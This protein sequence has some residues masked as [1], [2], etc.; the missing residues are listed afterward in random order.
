MENILVISPKQLTCIRLKFEILLSSY[1]KMLMVSKAHVLS[2]NSPDLRD[3]MT[4]HA[5]GVPTK[6]IYRYLSISHRSKT[7]K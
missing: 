1:N 5:S 2:A 3:I 7:Y 6:V 4:L